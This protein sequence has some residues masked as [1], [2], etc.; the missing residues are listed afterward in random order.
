MVANEEN[1]ESSSSDDSVSLLCS[2]NACRS[3][4]APQDTEVTDLNSAGNKEETKELQEH[5]VKPAESVTST[6]SQG[7]SGCPNAATQ[8]GNHSEKSDNCL[9]V[10]KCA[11]ADNNIHFKII[12][13]YVCCFSKV[14]CSCSSQ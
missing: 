5:Q 4:E 7:T 14:Y 3:R 10:L 12:M 6:L 2:F 1:P 11:F 8:S 13:S 9:G